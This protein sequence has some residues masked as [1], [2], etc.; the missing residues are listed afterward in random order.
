M[1]ITAERNKILVALEEGPKSWTALRLAYYGPE[2]AKLPASTSFHN[3]LQRMLTGGLIKKVVGGYARAEAMTC[4]HITHE[5]GGP[6][7]YPE[8]CR[9]L[10]WDC[11]VCDEVD[12]VGPACDKCGTTK[13]AA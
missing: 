5:N 9:E 7:D 10:P 3:Q 8:A 11:T 2:R 4:G 13:A 12:N 6:A 1:K